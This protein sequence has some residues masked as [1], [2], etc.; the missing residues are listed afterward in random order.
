MDWTLSDIMAK[1]RRLTGR[2]EE[3]QLSGADLI[4]AINQYYRN[5]L[6]LEFSARVLW[7]FL[8]VTA[9]PG[10]GGAYELPADVI[11]VDVPSYL[12]DSAGEVSPLSLFTRASTFFGLHPEDETAEDAPEDL[13][14]WGRFLYLRPLTDAPRTVKLAAYR[15]PAAL[16]GDSDKPADPS[17]GALIA[18]GTAIEILKE[19]GESDGA[20][21]LADLYSY[22]RELAA[23]GG[24]PHAPAGMLAAPR[25]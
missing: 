6:P 17:W 19:A 4:N 18:L 5:V 3:G 2:P 12:V 21:A 7:D 23:R 22:H 8:S 16:S 11:S 10:D 15:R 25:F 14:A 9:E 24:S 20:A 13:L 1:T